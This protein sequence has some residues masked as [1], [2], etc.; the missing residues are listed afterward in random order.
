MKQ[1]ESAHINEIIEE[2]KRTQYV[3]DIP[4]FPWVKEDGVFDYEDHH[5][6]YFIWNGFGYYVISKVWLDSGGEGLKDWQKVPW[7]SYPP[8]PPKPPKK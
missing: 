7:G 6:R 5:C 4:N 2:V 8:L 1:L 3:R